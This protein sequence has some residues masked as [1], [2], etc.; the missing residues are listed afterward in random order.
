MSDLSKIISADRHF[1]GIDD[2]FKDDEVPKDTIQK[3]Q[4]LDKI[5]K[6]D[7]TAKSEINNAVKEKRE[8]RSGKKSL[9]INGESVAKIKT[10]ISLAPD[11][12]ENL[13]LFSNVLRLSLGD[14]I[15]VLFE[16]Q[17]SDLHKKM[18]ERIEKL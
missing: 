1:K 2:F 9:K 5:E 11:V 7:E 15:T 6:K 17:K 13:V 3:I 14:L 12:Y 10:C 16:N 18:M 4:E 8:K